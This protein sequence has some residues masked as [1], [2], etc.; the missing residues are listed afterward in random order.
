MLEQDELFMDERGDRHADTSC[1]LRFDGTPV[2]FVQTSRDG[3]VLRCND[4]L[5]TMLG[6]SS[7]SD[8]QGRPFAELLE[9]PDGFD[10]WLASLGDGRAPSR[11]EFR[12]RRQDGHAALGPAARL[13]PAGGAGGRFPGGRHAPRH[14]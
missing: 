7:P 5:A 12:F 4:A 11:R 2:G 1:R 6:F 3:K 14:R 10:D 8:L 9:E 13:A